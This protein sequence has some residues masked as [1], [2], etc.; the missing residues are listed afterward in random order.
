MQA[1]GNRIARG[2]VRALESQVA[3]TA[4]YMSRPERAMCVASNRGHRRVYERIGRPRPE[5]CGRGDVHRPRRC[6]P[7]SPKAGSSA[8]AHQATQC[9]WTVGKRDRRRH[10]VAGRPRAGERCPPP[11]SVAV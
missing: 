2:V 6:S 3:N 10:R 4:R 9:A 7:A 8:A 11:R 5:R 1:S